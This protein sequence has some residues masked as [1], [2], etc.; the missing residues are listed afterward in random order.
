MTGTGKIERTYKFGAQRGGTLERAPLHIPTQ[1]FASNVRDEVNAQ[2][3]HVLRGLRVFRTGTFTDMFGYEH[4]WDDT[5]LELMVLHFT[6]L[7]ESG[8]FPDVPVRADHTFS[9]ANVVGYYE[10]LYRDAD[11][12][13]FLSADIEFTEPEAYQKWVRRTWRARSIEIGMYETNDNRSYYPTVMG[14]AFVDIPAVEG[15][16]GHARDKTHFSQAI[17]DNEEK[18]MPAPDPKTDP[19]GWT[20]AVAYAQWVE[21]ANYAKALDDWTKA[22]VYAKAIEDE[23]AAQNPPAAP[24]EGVPP[25]APFGAAPTTPTTPAPP[26][27]TPTPPPPT[28]GTMAFRVNGQQTADFRTVQT[29]IDVLEQFRKE[30][31][32]TVRRDFVEGLAKDNKISAAQIDGL[33]NHALSLSDEQYASFRASY[34]AA[35]S[36]SMFGQQV[37]QD[38][39]S[40][41]TSGSHPVTSA[42]DP[43]V[44]KEIVAQFRRIGM[45]E[46]KIV[47]TDSYKKLVALKV[48]PA[49]QSN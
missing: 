12:P 33:S 42:D 16:H 38:E 46:A 25:V 9:V 15:L 21:A 37:E 48:E 19:E 29:H 47:K 20:K 40:G 27:P 24:V 23:A 8:L 10:N 13:Q 6:L 22:V 11:D 2:G 1:K 30:T 39:R 35:P 17:M 18:T 43:E 45:D 44:L 28:G 26:P 34:D 5:H 14:L 41:D 36:L 3:N 4:T 32:D 7:R 49:T 31:S